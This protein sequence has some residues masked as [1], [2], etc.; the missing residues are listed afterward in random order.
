MHVS[1]RYK[2]ASKIAPIYANIK[3]KKN[4]SCIKYSNNI[5]FCAYILYHLVTMFWLVL[6]CLVF[7][8]TEA[9]QVLLVSM[10]GFRWD[11]LKKATTPNFDS[12]ASRGTKAEYI[13]NTFITKTFPCHYSVA[14]GKI[15]FKE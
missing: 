12:L 11:Y 1:L 4:I 2:Q 10:D 7:V 13:N 15:C 5:Y 14:T 6:L 9:G 8:F 3:D